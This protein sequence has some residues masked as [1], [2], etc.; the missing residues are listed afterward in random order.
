LGWRQWQPV[1]EKIDGVAGASLIVAAPAVSDVPIARFQL[2]FHPYRSSR[3]PPK[4]TTHRL[5]THSP[6]AAPRSIELG[7][8]VLIIGQV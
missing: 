5:T 7:S 1:G 3:V 2:N 6:I 8:L 4:L